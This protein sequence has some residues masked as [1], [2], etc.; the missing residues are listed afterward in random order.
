M[1][2]RPSHP[3]GA[4]GSAAD[5]IT[6]EVIRSALMVAVEEASIVVVRSSHSTWIQEGADAACALLDRD[7]QL[8]AQSTSTSLMHAASLRC[9]LPSLLADVAVDTMG[10]GDVFALNDPYR[11]GIHA[12]DILVFRP[13]VVDGQVAYFAGTVIHVADVGGSAAGGLAALAPDTFAEG[14]LL[15]PVALFLAGEPQRDVW[16]IIER[17][18]RVPAKVVG[19]VHALVA[20]VTVVAR[21]VD[22]LVATYGGPILARHVAD[23][24]DATELRMRE[25]LAALPAGIHTGRFEIDTDGV[26]PTRGF[27][28]AVRLSVGDGAID[29]DFTGTSAQSAGAINSSTSQTLSGII[30]AVRC[31][32]DPDI[33]MN[34]GCFRPVTVTLPA[35]TLVNPNPPAACGG[36]IVT[37]AAAVDAILAAMA[38]ARPE[39]AVAASGLIHVYTLSGDGWVTLLYEFGGIG[40]RSGSDGPDA[41]GCFFLGGRSVI[42]QLEPLEAQYPMRAVYARL[43]PDSGGAGRWRGGLGVELCVELTAA[44]RLTVRGDR[45]LGPPPGALGGGPGLGG[46]FAV[47]RADGT[48]EALATRQ[49][50]VALRAGDRFVLR[51]S[52]GGGLG[53]PLARDGR[54]VA[55]DVAEGRVSVTGARDD[56]GVVLDADGAVDD[57]ATL[58]RRAGRPA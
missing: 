54:L 13:I 51:T 6:A 8:V 17:N 35:G 24:L 49:Q 14:L 40:A 25:G 46:W 1:P 20:G 26:D 7:A 52:G 56:Y 28:V 3:P 33:P 32:V 29:A 57:A 41:T 11:G 42:P 36:R 47:Q 39:H 9:S 55:A 15:P 31:F 5:T 21:R 30:F 16:R 27:E 4:P 12:N 10:P 37:V 48:T 22:E 43:A 53:D 45:M 34:E 50:D 38:V 23:Y 2:Q 58:R 44:A 19:D 18:S